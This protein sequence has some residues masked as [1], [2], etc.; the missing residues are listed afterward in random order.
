MEGFEVSVS[1]IFWTAFCMCCFWFFLLS[2]P[3]FLEIVCSSLRSLCFRSGKFV[4]SSVKSD[5]EMLNSRGFLLERLDSALV[6]VGLCSESIAFV[7]L[8]L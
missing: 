3:I 1:M 7:I 5:G 2:L 8:C 6:V 4:W